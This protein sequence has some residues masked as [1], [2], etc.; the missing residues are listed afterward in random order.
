MSF[1]NPVDDVI[2]LIN[3]FGTSVTLYKN[4]RIFDAQTGDPINNLTSSTILVIPYTND[5]RETIGNP[6]TL[7]SDTIYFTTKNSDNVEINDEITLGLTTY[8]IKE[9]VEHPI[10]SYAPDS[11]NNSTALKS[12]KSV[13]KQSGI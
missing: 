7:T 6:M 13:K 2:D 3:E 8:I 4:Q 1:M 9:L 11:I 10:F 5:K 12:F